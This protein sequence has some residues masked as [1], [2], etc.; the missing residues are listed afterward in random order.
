MSTTLPTVI[1]QGVYS[2]IPAFG[3]QGRI[4]FATDTKKI[5]YDTGTSWIDVTPSVGASISSVQQEGYTYSADTG[6]ANAY[7]VVL[8]PAPTIIAGSTIV[9]KAASGNTGASTIAVNG[10][11]ATS[12]K[13]QGSTAL[14]S[15]DISA[16]QIVI[17]V[18]DG[19]HYQLVTVGGGGG[20]GASVSSIQ[21][22]GYTYAADTGAANAYVVA[23]SPAPTIAAG[24]TIVFKAA[25]ANTGP[26]TIAVNG[27]SA[28]SIKKQGSTALASGD[29][30][31][32]QIVILVYDGANFQLVTLAGGGGGGGGS[33]LGLFSGVMSAPPTQ[34]GI[35]L[36]TAW[37]HSGGLAVTDTPGGIAL[38]E[39]A[40]I[41]GEYWEGQVMA[42][43]GVPF[44]VTALVSVPAVGG[45]GFTNSQ[46][47]LAILDTLTGPA[48]TL[49]VVS[50]TAG[51]NR[52][53]VVDY[54]TPT[55]FGGT[56]RNNTAIPSQAPY[57]WLRL[58]DDGTD[59]YFFISNDGIVW[60]ELWFIGKSSSYLGSSGFNYLG[61]AINV[62][63]A[64]FGASL[65]SWTLTTP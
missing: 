33:A 45:P 37:N 44:T 11:S 24:S 19:T 41:S 43:P 10:G 36:T 62:N 35:G 60:S 25:N 50:F 64:A 7:A 16:G 32:G 22:E 6:A 52:W 51:G 54:S 23:L 18:Y 8:S 28:A 59:I 9:F 29:I 58:K 17:L 55:T 2:A 65:M 13:K 38:I 21:Q 57:Y 27:G 5:W 26:S 30:S 20:S 15:G 40:T 1:A 34:A 14:A 46:I 47:G 56:I 39:S 12:I 53:F 61:V 49:S 4:Y 31:A 48:Q 42:Y 3:I 63:G